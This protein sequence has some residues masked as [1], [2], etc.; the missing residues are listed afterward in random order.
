MWH[1][2]YAIERSDIVQSID[3]R[4]ETSV[5]AEY[6]IVDEGGKG[7]IIKEIREVF[8][9][10]RVAILPE[11]LIVE[12]VD[13]CNLTRFVIATE[14]GNALRISDFEGNKESDG[15]YGVVTSINVITC[16]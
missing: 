11:T 16:V 8:P 15:F 4:G 9:N 5:K 12:S 6:L 1:L 3:A 2:L 10:I 13:L 14:D 7:E